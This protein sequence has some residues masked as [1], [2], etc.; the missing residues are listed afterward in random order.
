MF[1]C[2]LIVQALNENM[3]SEYCPTAQTVSNLARRF[4]MNPFESAF[5]K[6]LRKTSLVALPGSIDLD[7]HV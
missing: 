4:D 2:S 1:I 7:N 5:G 6:A 3:V